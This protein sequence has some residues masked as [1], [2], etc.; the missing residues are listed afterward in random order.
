MDATSNAAGL[1]PL[2]WISHP[3]G[4]PEPGELDAALA[5]VG[6]S[7]PMPVLVLVGGAANLSEGV[8]PALLRLF[9]LLAPQLDALGAAV[10]DG[11]TAF[12]VMALMGRARRCTGA[13]FPLIG[14]APQGAVTIDTGEP[15]PLAR[16]DGRVRLDPE[17]THFMLVPGEGWGDESPWLSAVA[18]RLARGRGT[19]MLVAAGGAITRLDVA[20]RLLTGGRVLVLAGSGGTADRFADWRRDGRSLPDVDL[21]EA[22]RGLLEVLD[23]ADAQETLPAL[24]E[25]SLAR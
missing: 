21:A 18:D 12:G 22:G 24:V 13:R 9:E 2:V 4:R 17:H 8:A 19:L 23:L 15:N 5:A 20:H 16:E 7:D 3:H 10:I 25:Q 14:I 11:G 1:A 6:L